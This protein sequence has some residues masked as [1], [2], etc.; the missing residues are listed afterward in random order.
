MI[1]KNDKGSKN[2]ALWHIGYCELKVL[3]KQHVQ[4]HCDLCLIFE[5][6]EM[7]FPVKDIVTMK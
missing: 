1:H 2:I 5:K 7:N 3:E 4:E 6:Q